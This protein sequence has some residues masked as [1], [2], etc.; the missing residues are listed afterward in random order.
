FHIVVNQIDNGIPIESWFDDTADE[1]LLHLLPLL[2]QLISQ[3]E[4]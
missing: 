3:S 1:E 4:I 2:K